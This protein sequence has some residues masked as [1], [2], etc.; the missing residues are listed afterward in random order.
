MERWCR[1]GGREHGQ[2]RGSPPGKAESQIWLA[3]AEGPDCMSSDSQQELISG[4]LKVNS[5][6]L[7]E[8]RAGRVRGCREGELLSPGRQ[9]SAQTGNKGT[10]KHHLPLP[11]P[12]Q[13]SKGNQF[14]SLKFLA[15]PKNPMLCFCES[16]PPG[17]AGPLPQGTTNGKAS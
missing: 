5:S 11:S 1:T 2:W 16:I 15:P 10:G 13:N 7:R 9:S 12:S 14:P 17:A 4:M 6:A 8:W 3:K